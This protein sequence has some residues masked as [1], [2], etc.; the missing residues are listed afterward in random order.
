ME[1]DEESYNENLAKELKIDEI[2]DKNFYE[3]TPEHTAAFVAKLGKHEKKEKAKQR[4]LTIGERLALI[5]KD[6]NKMINDAL[7]KEEDINF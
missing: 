1:E 2:G 5:S 7:N 4:E 6:N 3:D